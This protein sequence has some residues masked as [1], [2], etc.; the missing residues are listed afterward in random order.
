[1]LILYSQKRERKGWRDRRL[2]ARRNGEELGDKES[3]R[4]RQR[5]RERDREREKGPRT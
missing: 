4:E 3:E 2:T 1:M 5:E